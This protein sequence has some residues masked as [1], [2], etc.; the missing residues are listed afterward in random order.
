MTL[1][2]ERELILIFQKLELTSLLNSEKSMHILKNSLHICSLCTGPEATTIQKTLIIQQKLVGI[3]RAVRGLLSM[4]SSKTCYKDKNISISLYGEK[5][6]KTKQLECNAVPM[7][8]KQSDKLVNVFSICHY[9]I[10]LKASKAC[11][12]TEGVQLSFIMEK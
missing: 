1:Q 9:I 10:L 3:W 8:L 2:Q 4:L 11:H 6:N 12:S 7:L 5:K